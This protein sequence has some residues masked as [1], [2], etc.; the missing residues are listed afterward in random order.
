MEAIIEYY[1]S[2]LKNNPE[3]SRDNREKYLSVI[4]AYT[5]AILSAML[6]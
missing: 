2:E 3:L 1:I 5:R 4:N 6:N